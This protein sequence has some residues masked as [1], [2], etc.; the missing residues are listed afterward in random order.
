MPGAAFFVL[1]YMSHAP[2]LTFLTAG[3]L[4]LALRQLE[5]SPPALGARSLAACLFSNVIFFLFFIPI[6]SKSLAINVL[7]VYAGKYTRY[8]VAHRWQPDLSDLVDRK[9]LAPK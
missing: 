5:S 7:N 4:L 9:T 3:V 8:A 1:F 6:S 2:Y